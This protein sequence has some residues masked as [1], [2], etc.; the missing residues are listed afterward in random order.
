MSESVKFVVQ[1]DLSKVLPEL[2]PETMRRAAAAGGE[3][4]RGNAKAN[5]ERTFSNAHGDAGLA[6]SIIVETSMKELGSTSECEVTV[7]PTALH[8]RIQ[9]L[10]GTIRPVS[11]NMLSWPT[12]SGERAF[13]KEVTLPPRPYLRP[14]VDEHQA[15]IEAAIAE[16]VR[17]GIERSSNG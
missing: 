1:T 6:G 10:G 9:E 8:G 13:A 14:A 11:K 16:Q 17:L 15:E 5:I 2:R 12:E 3:V 4:I 7:G